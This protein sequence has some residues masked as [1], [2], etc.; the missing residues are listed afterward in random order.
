[1]SRA[2]ETRLPALDV[3]GFGGIASLSRPTGELSPEVVLGRIG[4]E[5]FPVALRWLPRALR[6]DLVAIYGVARLIDEVGDAARGDRLALL[7]EVEADLRAAFT[8]AARHPLLRRLT[9][10]AAAHDLSP[11]PFVR[12]VDANR[13]DQRTPDLA[14]WDALRDY[15]RLSAEPIGELVLRVFGQAT[16]TN[17]RD[18]AAVCTALQVLEH[19]QDVAEDA[20]AGRCYLPA[21][22]RARFGVSPGDLVA[23]PASEALR[24]CVALQAERS[25]ALL[26]HGDAL[27]ARLR[28]FARPVVAGYAAGGWATAAAL[29]RAEFDPNRHAVRPRRSTTL[30]HALRLCKPRAASRRRAKTSSGEGRA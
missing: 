22:D 9:P 18:S 12:L 27:C 13:F 11:D 10:V 5:N 6:S 14:S 2:G 17:L 23:A 28:G 19:C 20:R 25:R 1:M 24:R 7:D 16:D 15:C 8:G 29:E 21:D 30:R 4:R 3:H 26:V